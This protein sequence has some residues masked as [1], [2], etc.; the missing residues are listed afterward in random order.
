LEE[1]GINLM[2]SSRVT[3]MKLKFFK[4]M[5]QNKKNWVYLTFWIEVKHL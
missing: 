5:M 4:W 1:G 2:Q 3:F